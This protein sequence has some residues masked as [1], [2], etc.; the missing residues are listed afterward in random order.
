MGN[1]F[2]ET[3]VHNIDRK[4]YET[5]YNNIFEPRCKVTCKE[6]DL[7]SRQKKGEAFECPHCGAKNE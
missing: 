5:N 3:S 1:D 6:C 2:D 4:K 7:S